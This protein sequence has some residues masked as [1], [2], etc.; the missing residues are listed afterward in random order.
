MVMEINGLS[1]REASIE[2]AMQP[3]TAVIFTWNEEKNIE[4]CLKSI[5]NLV[6]QILVVDSGSTDQTVE[7]CQKYNC[8]IVKHDYQNHISQWLWTLS[9]ALIKNEWVMPLDADHRV[10]TELFQAI[11]AL[12]LDSLDEIHGFYASHQLHFWGKRIRG[13]KEKGLRLFHREFTRI[14]QSEMVDF[15]FIV[16]GH[17]GILPGALIEDN[18]NEL[19]VDFLID[20]HQRFST[21]IAIEEVLRKHKLIQWNIRPSLWGNPDERI[22]WFKNLWY[23]APYLLRPWVYFAYRYFFR[24]GILDGPSGFIYHFLQALWFRM[25]VDIKIID[26]EKRISQDA[27]Y[28]DILYSIYMKRYEVE[29]NTNEPRQ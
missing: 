26:F 18:Q 8:E 29:E 6:S 11:Q 25:M 4:L 5:N 1:C 7:I 27:E 13:F 21:N 19:S 14:D 16:D 12:D 9:S 28:L 23:R 22:V 17:T 24:L 3:I 2:N 15:R 20:K 10:N